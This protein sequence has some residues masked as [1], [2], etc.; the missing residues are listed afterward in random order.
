[1]CVCVCV[2]VCERERERDPLLSE[3]W[4]PMHA[5]FLFESKG[6]FAAPN[7]SFLISI[8]LAFLL[9]LVC[10]HNSFE[11]LRLWPPD[12]ELTHW[13]HLDAGKD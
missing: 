6:V 5:S 9:T 2:C 10:K 8:T 4:V 11:P 7:I 13:K 3:V 12:D 1:M